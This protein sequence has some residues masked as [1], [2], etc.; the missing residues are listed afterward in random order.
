LLLTLFKVSSLFIVLPQ[1]IGDLTTKNVIVGS[2]STDPM[3]TMCLLGS[4]T[5]SFSVV[6]TLAAVLHAL[7]VVAPT[8]WHRHLGHPDPDVL[9]SLS[10]S[11]FIQCT[12]K[13]HDFCHACQLG[14]HIM[15][16]FCSSSHRVKH[17]FDLIPLDL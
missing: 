3:Y 17:P 9:S 14:K 5:P 11:S 1:T 15:L 12:S 13:K 4:L 6:V 16:P 2:N 7:T 10:W 8:T